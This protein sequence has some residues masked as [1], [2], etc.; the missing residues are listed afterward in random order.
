M[1]H[2]A[3]GGCNALRTPGRRLRDDAMTF[4]SALFTIF[5]SLLVVLTN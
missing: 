1:K 2:F 3:R 5:I 4:G